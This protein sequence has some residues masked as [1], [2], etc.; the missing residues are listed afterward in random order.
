[1]TAILLTVGDELLI[2][3]TVNTNVAWIGEQ[4]SAVGV[5][6]RRSV[7][8]SD[9]AGEIRTALRQSLN[10][11]DVVICTGGLGPTHDDITKKAIADEL[12]RALV[13]R[14]DVYA[15]LKAK[16]AARGRPMAERNRVQA[17]V[18]D[19]F[20]VLP[21]PIGTAPGLWY[22]DDAAGH[23][24]A[25][26]PGVPREMKVLMRDEVL[27]RVVDLNGAADVV[28]KTL[29][30]VGRGEADL[31]DSLGDLGAWLGP[32]L[33][34]A[35][36]PSY[37]VVK[38][39][40]TALGEHLEAAQA[41][42][43]EFE[44]YI[45]ERVGELIFG[46]GDDTLEASVGRMLRDRGLTLATAESCT[47]GLLADRITNVPGASDYFCGGVVVYGNTQKVEMLGVDEAAIREEGAVS[48][49]VVLQLAEGARR[50]FGTDLAVA[51]TGIAG[52]GGGT[53][54]KPVGTVW[55]GYADAHGTHAARLQLVTDR[56]LNKR[57]SVTAALNL[58]RR[59]LLRRDRQD[60]IPPPSDD[61]TTVTP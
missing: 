61:L 24:L 2:G 33:S 26:L 37:G 35:F 42:L 9:D 4:L 7:T 48:E 17:E 51:T 54:E 38:L 3:Q 55:L 11:A 15:D 10:D 59:Q 49:R 13:F 29:L 19:G 28:Q 32:D 30:T 22:E 16:Y 40:I 44:A 39:R 12:G 47:G 14:D 50:R 60:A 1:M 45:R 27:P 53:P 34:L 8:V 20:A 43:A 18:P 5:T 52:P 46:E 31:A 57:L 25:I 58:V 23:A 21:N 36:L 56:L 6:V 41:R